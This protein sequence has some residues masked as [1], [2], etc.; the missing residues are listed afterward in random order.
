MAPVAHEHPAP[1]EPPIVPEWLRV[2]AAWSWRLLVFG[3]AMYWVLLALARVQFLVV[4]LLLAIFVA[5]LL[6]PLAAWLNRL[7]PRT[8]ATFVAVLI[9]GGILGGTLT[10]LGMRIAAQGPELL[11][12]FK[13]GIGRVQS[14]L[15]SLPVPVAAESMSDPVGALGEEF[16]SR[17]GQIVK[18]IGSGAG[19]VFMS[20]SQLLLVIVFAFFIIRD[21]GQFVDY[22]IGKCSPNNG[23]RF[24]R[25]MESAWLTLGRYLRGLA[26]VA[27]AN[28]LET[29]LAAWVL[30]V[31]M[32]VP[33]IVVTFL[34]SFIPFA[35]PVIAGVLAA[36][37]ALADEGLVTAL[38]L[39]G[40][41]L[42]IQAIEGNVLQ[43]FIMGHTMKLHPIVI[44]AVV[45]AGALLAGLVGAFLALPVVAAVRN[46]WP[47]LRNVELPGE[48]QRIETSGEG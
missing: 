34:G 33:I 10:L 29:G 17:L 21:G 45:T 4:S 38:I 19:R 8:L 28:A 43:P 36:L 37:V 26:L 48:P 13:G 1:K 7:W 46:A 40:A 42:V 15:G 14:F 16:G 39:V 30:G 2:A 11:E 22:F 23:P 25:A 18:G 32:V 44:L 24:R 41:F 5:A 3:A 12:A 6:E 35:G 27:V 20:I 31:P 9:G 47:S